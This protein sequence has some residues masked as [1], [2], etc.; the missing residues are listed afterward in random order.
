[1]RHRIVDVMRLPVLIALLGCSLAR[2]ASPVPFIFDTDIG[3]DVD[4]ALALAMIHRL[5]SLGELKLLAVTVTKDCHFAAPYIDAVDTFYGRPKIP[6]GALP[7]TGKGKD[8]PMIQGP[9]ESGFYPHKLL[10]QKDSP[11]AVALLRRVLARQKDHSVVI[12]QV[13]FSTNLARLLQ[14]DRVLIERKVRLLSVMAG[15]FTTTRKE[16]NVVTDIPSATT[17]FSQW[18]TP[19][20]ASGFEIGE[21]ILYPASSIEKDYSYVPHHPVAD[22]YRLY[23]KMP[24]NRPTWDLTAVLYAIRPDG[25]YFGLSAP[26][27]ITVDSVGIT[28]FTESAGG[29]QRYL[30]VTPEQKQ[31]VLAELISLASAPPDRI[32]K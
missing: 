24:Y 31:K 7:Q 25:G 8:T 3:N 28:R 19:V 9:V 23:M 17:V 6:I 27:T 18:P 1:M 29:K 13:G 14:T 26:G 16:F 4:D 15:A 12:A 22:A 10:D 30:T 20:V 2:A 21:A 11:D 32:R 5:E